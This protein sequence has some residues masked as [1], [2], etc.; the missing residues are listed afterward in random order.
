MA[1][2]TKSI[3]V[4]YYAFFRETI[5]RKGETIVTQAATARDLFA[6]IDRKYAFQT[7]HEK[8]RVAV[9]D[10]IVTWETR[11]ADGDVVV[12]LTPFGGG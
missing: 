1:V 5:G 4:E 6:E 10:C 8:I 7:D 11:L 9:N 12:F 2:D 3:L